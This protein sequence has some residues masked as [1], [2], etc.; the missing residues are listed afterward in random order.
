MAKS[1]LWLDGSR[2]L[3]PAEHEIILQK[4][5]YG[6]LGS[7]SLP[8]DGHTGSSVPGIKRLGSEADHTSPS[9]IKVK[10]NWSDNS[11]PPT[12]PYGM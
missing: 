12:W 9:S 10:S 1:V 11:T 5:P 6:L 8:I 3:S 7:P 2:L 4:S